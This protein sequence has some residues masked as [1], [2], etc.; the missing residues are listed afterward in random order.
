M[1]MVYVVIHVHVI[2]LLASAIHLMRG[3]GKMNHLFEAQGKHIVAFTINTWPFEKLL[4]PL[5]ICYAT[6][7]QP[8]TGTTTH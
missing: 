7:S 8:F 5:C 3:I 1:F 6:A 4:S 2:A